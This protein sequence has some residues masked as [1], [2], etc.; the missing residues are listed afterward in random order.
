MSD[1]KKYYKVDDRI[2]NGHEA[3]GRETKGKAG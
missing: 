1:K 2:R 3:R